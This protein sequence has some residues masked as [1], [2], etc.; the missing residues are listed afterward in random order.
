M[1]KYTYVAKNPRTGVPTF[2]KDGKEVCYPEEIIE[3]INQLEAEREG[4][5]MVP[6]EPTDD[7]IEHLMGILYAWHVPPPLQGFEDFIKE[8]YCEVVSPTGEGIIADTQ[9]GE[10]DDG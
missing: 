10:Q 5:A 2:V 6:V 4:K 1:S 8:F 3:Y 9:Q 7:K